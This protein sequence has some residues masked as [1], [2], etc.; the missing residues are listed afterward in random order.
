MNKIEFVSKIEETYQEY[1]T[2][3]ASLNEAQMLQPRICGEWSV[4]DVVAH[5][6]WYEREM[7][8]V[9][10][11]RALTGSDF[12]NLSLEERNAAIH[13]GNRDRPLQELLAESEQVHRSMM[14]L[15]DSL[16]DED[17]LDAGRFREMPPDWIPW[18]VIASN[19][20]EHYPEHTAFI[21]KAFP[22]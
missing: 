20:F 17:L 3:L 10:T 16:T 19:T 11:A 12:W 15:L 5:I 4:K 7:V 18:Q 9:L 22:D 21:R 14:K 1:Q 6:T 8:G 13:A 2:V